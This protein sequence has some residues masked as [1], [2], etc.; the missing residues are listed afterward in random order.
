[1]ASDRHETNDC[2][3]RWDPVKIFHIGLFGPPSTCSPFVDNAKGA[4][5]AACSGRESSSAAAA[6]GCLAL[7]KR[8]RRITRMEW[9]L[10][11]RS[12]VADG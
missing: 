1:M 10:S 9:T 12:V 2:S 4:S 8:R 11:S 5:E 3:S 7:P 6:V